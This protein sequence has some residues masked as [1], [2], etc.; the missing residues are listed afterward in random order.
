MEGKHDRVIPL[1]DESLLRMVGEKAALVESGRAISKEFEEMQKQL[2]ALHLKLVDVT[3]EIN[4]KKLAIFKRVEKL[5]KVQL[6]EFEIPV[7]T[8]VRD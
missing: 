5:A 2:E 3:S 7:T 8:E 4:T 1:E 6:S